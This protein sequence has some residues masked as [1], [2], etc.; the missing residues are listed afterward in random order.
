LL[1]IKDIDPGIRTSQL[2][3]SGGLRFLS[4]PGCCR[5]YAWNKRERTECSEGYGNG[6]A[7][8]L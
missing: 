8:G 5:Y 4:E 2:L 1:C 7:P 3:C 6:W